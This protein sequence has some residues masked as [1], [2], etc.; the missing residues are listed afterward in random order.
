[1][2]IN[3]HL[4]INTKKGTEWGVTLLIILSLGSLT[5]ICQDARQTQN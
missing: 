4:Q 2:N 1:M 3:Q 5:D